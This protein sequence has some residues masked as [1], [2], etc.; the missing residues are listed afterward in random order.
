MNNPRLVQ[1]FNAGIAFLKLAACFGV[2]SMHFGAY[3]FFR[4]AAVPTFVLVSFYL[5]ARLFEKVNLQDLG[6]RIRRL[7]I[8]FFAWGIISLLCWWAC[9]SE[10][11]GRI[12]LMQ[13]TCGRADIVSAG[14]LYYLEVCVIMTLILYALPRKRFDLWLVAVIVF[15]FCLQYCNLNYRIF[16]PMG[17]NAMNTFGRICEFITYASA[18]LLL[19]HVMGWFRAKCTSKWFWFICVMGFCL[20]GVLYAFKLI[21]TPLGFASQGIAAFLMTVTFNLPFVVLGEYLQSKGTSQSSVPMRV[22]QYVSSLTGGM[23]YIHVLVGTALVV[24]FGIAH[25]LI[26]TILVFCASAV[27]TIILGKARCLSWL[28]K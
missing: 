18:G 6:R 13:L 5:S 9:G 1:K 22:L 4:K 12:V 27:A 16:H 23:Y 3:G 10:V 24:V 20:A 25:S 26:C 19:A 2:V 14:H 17:Y 21:P 15:S 7:A 8:P 11:T 28:V